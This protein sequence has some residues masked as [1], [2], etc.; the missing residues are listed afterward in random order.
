MLRGQLQEEQKNQ[1][2]RHE[3]LSALVT[4]GAIKETEDFSRWLCE[5][6]FS[7]RPLEWVWMVAWAAGGHHLKLHH[8][9]DHERG[10][11]A[12]ISAVDDIEFYGQALP[13][14]LRF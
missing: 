8:Y 14:P 12:R 1:P 6:A 13:T 2:L 10:E 11:L 7:H 4:T 3:V 9:A 5:Q